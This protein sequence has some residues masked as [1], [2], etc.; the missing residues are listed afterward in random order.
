MWKAK[1]IRIYRQ[2]INLVTEVLYFSENETINAIHFL[3][4][5]DIPPK[6]ALEAKIKEKLDTLERLDKFIGDNPL[7]DQEIIKDL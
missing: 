6:A 5:F 3:P 1:I 2:G 4:D 7:D